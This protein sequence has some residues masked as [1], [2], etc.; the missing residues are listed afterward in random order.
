MRIYVTGGSGCVGSN[1]V[2][3]ALEAGHEVRLTGRGWDPPPELGHWDF[4]P[5]DVTS[6]DEVTRS[7]ERF[8]PDVVIHSAILNDHDQMTADRDLAWRAYVHP[9]AG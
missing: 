5:V 1:V 8:G 7:I 4:E 6:A 3:V 9:S 2:H